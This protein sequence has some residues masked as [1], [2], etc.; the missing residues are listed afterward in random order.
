[1]HK[2][3]Y[4][5]KDVSTNNQQLS[6][7]SAALFSIV[8]S[9]LASKLALEVK[10]LDSLTSFA[11]PGAPLGEHKQP[12]TVAAFSSYVFYCSIPLASKLARSVPIENGHCFFCNDR[13]WLF[14]GMTGFEPATTRPPDAYSNRAELHPEL[15]LQR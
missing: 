7:L 14:V 10:G 2:N 6:L 3:L 15:R 12:T 11:H 9:C 4:N 8:L 5:K 1:M 13:C